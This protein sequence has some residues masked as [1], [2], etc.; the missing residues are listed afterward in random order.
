MK[1]WHLII[2]RDPLPGSRN[3]AVDEFLFEKAR[4]SPATF[5]RFYRWARPTAS[6]GYGQDAE[7]STNLEFCR[8]N[9][10]DVVRRMTGGKVVLH[11]REL[12][13]SLASSDVETFSS[14]LRES[15]KLISQALVVGLESM[16][17]GARLAAQSPPAY[18]RKTM[19]CFAFPARDEIEIDGLKIIG[20]AQKRTGASFIQH[21]SVPLENDQALLKSVARS[22]AEG[23]DVHMTCLSEAL[24]RPVAF[25]WAAARFADGFEQFFGVEFE[26]LVLDADN[27][28]EVARI[29]SERYGNSLWTLRR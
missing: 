28:R 29:E 10:V 6:L 14:T 19:P 17:L 12:T 3:M 23:E 13:Y 2:E 18:L 20:S 24:G 25:E 11:H 4:L 1:S 8:S 7:R 26:P 9:G 15:Y 21:G 22:E 27:E 16:G 5:L